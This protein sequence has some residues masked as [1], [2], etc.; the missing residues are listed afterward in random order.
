MVRWMET[1]GKDC[2]MPAIVIDIKNSI[3]QKYLQH[4]KAMLA[5]K[6]SQRME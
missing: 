5:L 1:L 4:T 3:I 2:A 6:D